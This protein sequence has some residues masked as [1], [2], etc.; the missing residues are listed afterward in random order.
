MI[1]T[2]WFTAYPETLIRVENKTI[3]TNMVTFTERVPA[4]T[5]ERNPAPGVCLPVIVTFCRYH[6]VSL[7][8]STIVHVPCVIFLEIISNKLA[9]NPPTRF[10]GVVE[11]N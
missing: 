5:E 1:K 2:I 3:Y 7:P 6:K 9:W 8:R 11:S 10:S 4:V